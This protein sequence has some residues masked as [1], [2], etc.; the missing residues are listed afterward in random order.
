M[1]EICRRWDNENSMQRTILSASLL[2]TVFVPAGAQTTAMAVVEKNCIACHGT[3]SMGGLDL[4][5]RELA[6]KGGG[7]GPALVPGK[8]QES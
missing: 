7:R 5:Q 1:T 3:A 4:R 8:P 6:L 2:L